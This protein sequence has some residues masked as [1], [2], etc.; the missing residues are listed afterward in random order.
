MTYLPLPSNIFLWILNFASSWSEF[1]RQIVLPSQ[2]LAL[3]SR[4]IRFFPS[5]CLRTLVKRNVQRATSSSSET[6]L[7]LLSAVYELLSIRMIT[8]YFTFANTLN[9]IHVIF[10][11]RSKFLGTIHT[12]F[13]CIW[14]RSRIGR[15]SKQ[16][17]DATCGPSKNHETSL[18]FNE[19]PHFSRNEIW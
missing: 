17:S 4:N 3:L 12:C 5:N 7:T 19:I 11:S 8:F 6:V 14:K 15:I 16:M 9:W 18:L 13:D 1:F 10:L 2:T